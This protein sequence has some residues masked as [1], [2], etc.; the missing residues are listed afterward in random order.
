MRYDLSAS[1]VIV[2]LDNPRRQN[3]AVSTLSFEKT[4]L[5]PAQLRPLL[6]S[7]VRYGRGKRLSSQRNHLTH[8][9]RPFFAYFRATGDLWPELS[10]NWQVFLLRFFQ[11]YLVD[12]EWSQASP[13][14]RM[15]YWSTVVGSIFDF[16]V[17]DEIVP[18]DVVIPVVNRKHIKSIAV[19]QS[20]LGE[21]SIRQSTTQ[22]EPQKL[23]V[24]LDFGVSDAEYLDSVEVNCRQRLELIKDVC[25]SHWN[26][27][28]ADMDEGHRLASQV[29][30]IDI[31]RV[32]ASGQYREQLRGG[33]PVP[34][35]SPSHPKGHIWALAVTRYQ[36]QRGAS[37]ECVSTHTL[38]ANPFFSR[39]AMTSK[40]YEALY[41][42]TAMERWQFDEYV[43][44]AQLYRF[45]GILSPLDAAAACC[46]LT[47]EHPNFTSDSLQGAKLLNA[48]GKYHLILTDN[49]ESSILSVD[50]PRAGLRKSVALTP[51][52]QK[53]IM[54]IVRRTAPLRE[55][56]RRAGNK[57]WRYLFLGYLMSGRLGLIEGQT[58]LLARDDKTV[59]LTRLY[60]ILVE[61]G[62]TVGRFDYRRIRNTVGVLRWFETGSIQEMSRRLG[63]SYRVAME[64]YLPPALLHAW[65]TRIIRRF[66][67]TLIV[68]AAHAED[69]LLDVTDFSTVADLQYF[70]AQLI[71]DYPTNS[72]PLANEIQSRLCTF[73]PD[74][75]PHRLPAPGVLNIRLS[76]SS[77]SYLYAFSDLVKRTLTQ[78]QLYRVDSQ[79]RLAPIQ[80]VDLARLMRHACESEDARADLS[81]LLDL[82]RLRSIHGQA[83]AQ[84]SSI[85]A[86]L[87]NLAISHHWGT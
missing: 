16:F 11:F 78:E 77:L 72:S 5:S 58:R 63:N 8:F 56:L 86:H 18:C 39:L 43:G 26:A 15:S 9:L 2:Y 87:S 70:I 25:L 49:A 19:D 17:A 30:D 74:K 71:L 73:V 59:S 60:P 1:S 23:L 51:I 80:F 55:V 52:A 37:A 14:T 66:Q 40:S 53:L 32:I 20:V 75:Q 31:E 33:T 67:N 6:D 44:Y 81:E 34:L 10:S 69:Y 36:L 68:L 61:Y 13:T 83:V 45:A 22:S 24:D 64:H 46:L 54:D 27:L 21:Q 12:T 84:Q 85:D 57:A 35:A 3:P 47:I 82:P 62:L 48:K 41:N 28:M 50:K 38:R 42:H 79:S 65:N 29:S 76:A 7:L 4:A